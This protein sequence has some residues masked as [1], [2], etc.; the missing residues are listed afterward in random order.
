MISF[1]QPFWL[2]FAVPLA[3]AVY[4]WPP[5]SRL[6][7]IA[8]V[9]A[10]ILLLTALAGICWRFAAR[11]GMVV[12]VIDRSASMPPDT[13]SVAKEGIDILRDGMADGD[14]LAVVS[15]ARGCG[16]DKAPG[17]GAFDGF[18]ARIDPWR[19]DLDSALRTAA[20]LIPVGVPGRVLLISD[21]DWTG[22]DPY[23]A[24]AELAS[25]GVAVDY[26]RHARPES[27]DMAVAG[28]E[29]PD[30][31]EPGERF[32]ITAWIY[33]HTAGEADLKLRRNDSTLV[34]GRREL[35]PGMNRVVFHDQAGG[36]GVGDYALS[37]TP[38]DG[39]DPVKGNNNAKFLVSV[40][41]GKPVL[42][43]SGASGSALPGLLR[44]SGV[45]VVADN[46]ASNLSIVSLA[47]HSALVLDNFS[48]SR[49][50]GDV[51][52]DIA[53]WVNGAGGGL[54][55][56]G[57][58]N[59]YG[60][61]GYFKSPLEPVLP[62]SMELKQEHRKLSMAIVVAL[63]RSGSMMAS[64]G[65]GRTKMDLA[66]IS[67]AQVLDMMTGNDEIGVV[68]V[69]S[70]AHVVVPLSQVSDVPGARS[71]ILSIESMGGGIFVF[72]A[73][74]NSV[75]MLMRSD[76]GARHV[77]LFADAADAEEPGQYKELLANC[78]DAGIT[79]SVIGLGDEKD[80]DAGLLK[81]IA[82]RG[83]GR[84]FFTQKADELPR[85]FA[86]DT[87]VVAR[88]TFID[89]P[90]AVE[91]VTPVME[92]MSGDDFGAGFEV[93]G[94][95]LCY[96]RPEAMVS[97]VTKDEYA[98]P[99][100]AF[101]HSGEGRAVCYAGEADGE[102]TGAAA[103]WPRYGAMMTA[104]T[105][106]AMGTNGGD[107]DFT[108]TQRVNGGINEVRINLDPERDG[109][110]FDRPPSVSVISDRE[111]GPPEISE[112]KTRW[113]DADTMIAEVPLDGDSPSLS[114]VVIP[115]RQALSLP[116]VR[117][118]YSPEFG[119]DGRDGADELRRIAG[120]GGGVERLDIP[121]I[122]RDIPK[123]P[124]DIPL[125]RWLIL[126]AMMIFLFEI[127]ERRTAVTSAVF[128]A[129]FH[130][131]WRW[132]G[133]IFSRGAAKTAATAGGSGRRRHEESVGGF[134]PDKTPS[135]D[136]APAENSSIPEKTIDDGM[137]NAMRE[138]R[139]RS[140]R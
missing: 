80:C 70:S 119:V 14:R 42:C 113:L 84:C 34:G 116:P 45:D 110:P 66:N 62:V 30:S 47:G 3:L 120:V 71:A 105:R 15:F 78:V 35:T 17:S 117:L 39:E 38:V 68:A 33:S 138:A 9:L 135:V 51:M 22:G 44:R 118:P 121:A 24:A 111:D 72:E 124:R 13:S 1:T 46:D 21:G 134:S 95:N 58:K 54:M 108:V 129:V 99:V 18:V 112:V 115:G 50:G 67:T 93:G 76:A 128:A 139:R 59:S 89:E 11:G 27:G 40:R 36:P 125:R 85:L 109:D 106:W 79:V 55:M 26:R 100:T 127:F 131:H 86:Q 4:L 137:M 31:V 102:H 12:A 88:N 98:A 69:D 57:G 92:L 56:T 63:D 133:K 104:M 94:Y 10:T 87:F 140:R 103:S 37:L 20:A 114:S 130:R 48:A 97:A 77:I 64:A 41:G 101:W 19:S 49:L 5:P 32:Q 82:A 16:V 75:N 107:D 29:A 81:D 61:G 28:I 122:W 25:N 132:S 83:G 136:P 73:L 123:T 43:L 53:A 7:T 91:I 6:T 126:A 90:T 2:V 60:I 65:F 23:P 52:T 8:R 96:A 74:V